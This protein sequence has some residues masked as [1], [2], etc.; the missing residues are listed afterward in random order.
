MTSYEPY[1]YDVALRLT[2]EEFEDLSGTAFSVSI[3]L[4]NPRKTKKGML[5]IPSFGV[6]QRV[7][8]CMTPGCG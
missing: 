7:L 3:T 1:D 4:E 6:I 2:P 5:I 8:R